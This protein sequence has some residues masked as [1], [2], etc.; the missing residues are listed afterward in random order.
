MIPVTWLFTSAGDVPEDDGWLS[1]AERE[2]LAGLHVPWRRVDWRLGRWTAKQAVGAYLGVP[3]ETIEVFPAA[4]GAPEPFLNG[5][6]APAAISLSHRA[7][8]A[9]CAVAPPGTALGCDIERVEPRSEAF[10][11]DFLTEPERGMVEAASPEQRQLL[12]NLIWSAKESVLKALRSGLRQDT[13]TVEIAL[14]TGEGG[15]GWSQFIAGCEDTG[16]IFLGWWRREDD[17]I[18]TLAALP[19]PDLPEALDLRASG[20][21]VPD[22]PADP[23]P[24]GP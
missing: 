5:G 13:R 17:L 21:P 19:S 14:P 7:G 9:V 11:R 20:G 12:A 16:R 1:P 2:T 22:V 23:G 15:D 8:W 18:L 10:V 3:P 24:A 6:P 4:D